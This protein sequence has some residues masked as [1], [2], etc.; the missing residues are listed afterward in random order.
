[1]P[2]EL[3]ESLRRVMPGCEKWACQAWGKLLKNEAGNKVG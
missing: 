2:L 3:Q 1:M